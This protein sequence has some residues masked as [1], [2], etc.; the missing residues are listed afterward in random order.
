MPTS[1]TNMA[2]NITRIVVTGFIATAEVLINA[3]V[4]V[5][6]A[7]TPDFIALMMQDIAVLP[8][9]SYLI[10]RITATP[11][12]VSVATGAAATSTTSTTQVK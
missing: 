7:N 3:M 11:T 5:H 2:V 10:A 4:V 6:I 12:S 9:A 1:L 8:T